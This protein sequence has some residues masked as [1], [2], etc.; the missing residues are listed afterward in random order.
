MYPKTLLLLHIVSTLFSFECVCKVT[1]TI[2]IDT[3]NCG[4]SYSNPEKDMRNAHSREKFF[5]DHITN[6]RGTT[7][8]ILFFYLLICIPLTCL[9][10]FISISFTMCF[11]N[12]SFQCLS[13]FLLQ[14]PL[15]LPFHAIY[16][17]T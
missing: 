5:H 9:C 15:H 17:F 11:S 7:T 14:Q 6:R 4:I 13:L 2:E 16:V 3:H 1:C 8:C 12:F 10:N